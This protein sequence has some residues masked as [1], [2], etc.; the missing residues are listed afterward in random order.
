MTS[1]SA[2][3]VSSRSNV[4]SR[5]CATTAR[6]LGSPVGAP[7]GRRR[8]RPQDLEVQ[9]AELELLAR[10]GG[11]CRVP[12]ARGRRGQAALDRRRPPRR[13]R[14]AAAAART[15][16]ITARPAPSWSSCAWVITSRSRRRTPASRS[17]R[18]IG[19]SGGPVS[20][21]IDAPSR[22]ISVASPWPMSR[23]DTTSSP[24]TT[25]AAARRCATRPAAAGSAST[26]TASS[27]GR[28]R[29]PRARG[30]RPLRVAQADGAQRGAPPPRPRRT[31]PRSPAATHA[32]GQH[33]ARRAARRRGPP[34]R[35][36]RAAATPARRA[37]PRARARPAR[38]RPRASRAT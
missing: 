20:T 21:S 13:R 30:R 29:G 9:P 11:D 17:R 1:D 37:A 4:P 10:P 32:D 22:W 26:A 15:A 38:P 19:P 5:T 18:T 31:P 16:R 28:I 2:S 23:N 33:G 12:G 27:A 36:S 7:A 35:R 24:G 14:R 8:G 3:A 34:R 25:G 6:S